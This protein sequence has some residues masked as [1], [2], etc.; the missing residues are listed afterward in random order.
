[1]EEPS[2]PS[3]Q[4]QQVP[5]LGLAQYSVA[6]PQTAIY[7]NSDSTP[8][9]MR[10]L[11]E[12]DSLDH[13]P[14][15]DIPMMGFDPNVPYYHLELANDHEIMTPAQ[16]AAPQGIGAVVGPTFIAPDMC[17]PDLKIADL[18]ADEI[19]HHN[20]WEP[21]PTLPDLLDFDKPGGLDITAASSNP[22]AI[23]PMAPDLSEYDRPAGLEMPGPLVADPAMPDLQEPQLEQDVH[24]SGRPGD[25]APDALGEMR[26]DASYE[27]MPDGDYKTMWMQQRGDNQRRERHLGLMYKGLD[28]GEHEYR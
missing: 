6:T 8:P 9:V 2:Y 24:M 19:E 27:Q 18:A 23:D 7:T 11:P 15:V 14:G 17:V 3:V 10:P 1:M 22:L 12:L 4:N 16:L 21:D 5:D 25:L 26:D 28:N 13:D 20:E